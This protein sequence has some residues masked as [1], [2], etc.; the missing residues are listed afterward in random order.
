[1]WVNADTKNKIFNNNFVFTIYKTHTRFGFREMDFGSNIVDFLERSS[2]EE[3]KWLASV[4]P[5]WITRENGTFLEI[6]KCAQVDFLNFSKTI[7]FL[8]RSSGE[9]RKWL[10]SVLPHWITRENDMFLEIANC[11]QVN[12]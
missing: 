1:M 10:A 9:E 11:A 2:G 4:L 5:H 3:R 12:F 7:D 6:A 8:E